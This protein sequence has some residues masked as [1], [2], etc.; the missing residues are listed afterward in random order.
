MEVHVKGKGKNKTDLYVAMHEMDDPSKETNFEN[1]LADVNIPVGEVF[2]SPKLTGTNGVLHVGEVY[3][4]D[5]KFIDLEITFKDGMISEY[6]CKNFKTE[7]ENK[8]FIKENIL[9]RHKTLPLGEFAIGTNTTAYVAAKKLG[10]ESKMPIL[11]AEKMGPHF[12][13]GDTCY[14]HAEEVKV[15]NPDGKEI[16]ARDNE[17]AALRSV[18]P[19]KAYFNC[20]TDITI[21]YDELAE[22]TAVKKD[23][24]RITIIQNGRFVL[25]GTEELNEPLQELS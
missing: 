7:E 13:V 9:F 6:T 21:P 1:C 2:T 18:N 4:N 25:P 14:S 16:V 8:A 3:L 5:L 22:L 19:S 10:V 17:V 24:D 15:Y 23:R 11:I 20:H 12:A